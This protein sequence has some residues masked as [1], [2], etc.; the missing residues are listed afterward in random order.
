LISPT[1]S[2]ACNAT[3][4]DTLKDKIM[5]DDPKN[6]M[7]QPPQDA[8]EAPAIFS[9]GHTDGKPSITRRT[10]LE[11]AAAVSGA[12]LGAPPSLLG[13]ETNSEAGKNDKTVKTV[14][15]AHSER[16]E[17]LAI[18]PDGQWLASG[19]GEGTLKLWTL[20]AGALAKCQ[21]VSSASLSALGFSPDGTFLI[22]GSRSYSGGRLQAWKFPGLKEE[23]GFQPPP[24]NSFFQPLAISPDCTSVA[25]VHGQKLQLLHLPDGKPLENAE[26]SLKTAPTK[27]VF[28][29]DGKHLLEIN[30]SDRID[31]LSNPKL[32]L[33]GHLPMDLEA[34]AAK[35]DPEAQYK[36]GMKFAKGHS[37][38]EYIQAFKWLNLAVQNGWLKA[39]PARFEAASKLSKE[40]IDQV[41]ESAATQFQGTGRGRSGRGL[42]FT[43]LAT[44]RDGKMVIAGRENG[45]ISFIS[46]ETG[47]NLKTLE[48]QSDAPTVLAVSADG[49][50]LASAGNGQD[51][52]LWSLPDGKLLA[53][54]EGHTKKVNALAITPNGKLLASG[55]DDKTIRLWSLPDG[56]ELFCLMDIAANYKTSAG[57]TYKSQNQAGETTTFTLPCGSPIPAG[58]V[59]VCNC[60]P[61]SLS[62]PTGHTQ[63]F[64]GTVCTC[65]LICTCNTVCTCQSVGGGGGGYYVSYWY[66]N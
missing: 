27:V 34:D 39:V 65:D 43:C 13:S 15:Y 61:G 49:K 7:N 40:E 51:I 5:A 28:T 59:C 53:T 64:T 48:A 23:N 11:I 9:L 10:F 54:L 36:L 24:E 22:S 8:D 63:Q 38:L 20:P 44:T 42:G 32:E 3:K 52:K 60:V 17:S 50:M 4:T 19:G 56:K 6:K 12:A 1:Q 30:G 14:V 47:G 21:D 45:T 57:V 16:V 37:H 18:S 46:I 35:G 26:A 31:I 66:P 41:K 29:P 58:A 25:S 55:S 62:M 2:G 33:E